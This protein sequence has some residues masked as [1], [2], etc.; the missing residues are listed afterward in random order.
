MQTLASKNQRKLQRKAYS[1]SSQGSA[2]SILM[3]RSHARDDYIASRRSDMPADFNG[4]SINPALFDLDP[5]APPPPKIT[6]E[7]VVTTD[8]TEHFVSAAKSEWHFDHRPCSSAS[9]ELA[10]NDKRSPGAW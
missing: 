5:D 1:P 8:I 4:L 6:S 10:L 2:H 7:A 9:S 3:A